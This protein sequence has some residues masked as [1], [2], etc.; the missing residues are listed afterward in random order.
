M[1]QVTIYLPEAVAAA[2]RKRARRANKSVSAWIAELIE[3]ET[4]MRTWPKALLDVLSS[5]GGGIVEPEDPPPEDV[6]PVR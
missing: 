1:A 3:R 4:G 6:D 5:G 2:T